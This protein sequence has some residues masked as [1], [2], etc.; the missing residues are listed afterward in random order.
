MTTNESGQIAGSAWRYENIVTFSLLKNARDLDTKTI[1]YIADSNFY[2]FNLIYLINSDLDFSSVDNF[3]N[4]PKTFPINN[5]FIHKKNAV[6]ELNFRNLIDD[7][8]INKLLTSEYRIKFLWYVCSIPDF[9]TLF[10]DTYLHLLKTIVLL[11]IKNDQLPTPYLDN[12]IL[13]H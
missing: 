4:S 10:T 3:L 5:Y 1:Q 2:S 11:L 6:D 9:Q 13:C 7:L 8:S 12:N